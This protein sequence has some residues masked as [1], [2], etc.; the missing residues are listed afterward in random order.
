MDKLP[1]ELTLKQYEESIIKDT[2]SRYSCSRKDA[3]DCHSQ[4]YVQEH[5]KYCFNAARFGKILKRSVLDSLFELGRYRIFH[6]IPG[7][8]DLWYKST[9]KAYISPEVRKLKIGD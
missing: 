8:L 5:L 6:D 9:G 3:I 1:H 7:Y 4:T 2:M